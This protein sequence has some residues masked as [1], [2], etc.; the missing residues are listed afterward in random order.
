[1]AK[2]KRISQAISEAIMEE[3]IRDEN[4]VMIG[5]D[6]ESGMN[7]NSIGLLDKFGKDR[8]INT[9]ISEAAYTGMA[10]G[11]A[12][13]GM[14]PVIEYCINTLQY[15]SME[16]LVNQA[17][18]LRYMTGGQVSIPMVAI[19]NMSGAGISCAAQHSDSTW[20]QLL[21]MGMKV[22]VPSGPIDAKGL[23]KAA[24]RDND[25]VVIYL[26]ALALGVAEE[27]PEDEYLIPLG[28]GSV[29]K[30]GTDLTIVAVGHMVPEAMK[31]AKIYEAKG[32]SIEVIDPRTLYPLDINLILDSVRKTGK[33][34]VTDDGYRFCSWSSEVAATISEQAFD[35]LKA[36]VK[37]I[38]RPVNFVPYSRPLE[39]TTFPYTGQLLEGVAQLT[40]VKPDL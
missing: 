30:E 8:V 5:E 26:P 21:H 38:T 36:P 27:L 18:K 39:W 17:V 32:V 34:I 9:P 24:I 19:V 29:K 1:M 35:N 12:M 15:V 2:K 31:V 3:M 23:M 6:V 33:V 10:I 14:R 11:A 37:R 28:K 7:G 40:G 25:P 16:M 4:V 20:A 22:I 13:K